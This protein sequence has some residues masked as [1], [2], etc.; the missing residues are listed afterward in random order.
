MKIVRTSQW[1]NTIF[2]LIGIGIVWTQTH[3]WIAVV[4]CIIAAMHF[5]YTIEIGGEKYDST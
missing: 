1:L 2:L 5:T 3:N 4:G